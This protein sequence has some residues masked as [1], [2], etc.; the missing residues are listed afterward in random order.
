M[1]MKSGTS[2]SGAPA[3]VLAVITP[4]DGRQWKTALRP[5]LAPTLE[6]RHSPSLALLDAPGGPPADALLLDMPDYQGLLPELLAWQV[7]VPRLRWVLLL[8]P[9]E[10]AELPDA[11]LL[12]SQVQILPRGISPALV[13]TALRRAL[14]P[15]SA[16]Q[17]GATE[18][19]GGT[20]PQAVA[21]RL[22]YLEAEQAAQ[23]SFARQVQQSLLPRR[24]IIERRF[25]DSFV[26]YEAKAIVAGDLYWYYDYFDYFFVAV[27]D[28]TGYGVSGA[29]LSVLCSNLLNQLV[30]HQQIFA[31]DEVLNELHQR[32]LYSLRAS[33]PDTQPFDGIEISLCRIEKKERMIEFAGAGLPLW[34]RHAG[35]W[36]EIMGDRLPLAYNGPMVA[37]EEVFDRSFTAHSLDFAPGDQLYLLTDGV[38]DQFGGADNR[39]LGKRRLLDWLQQIQTLP[40][41]QQRDRLLEHLRT[42]TGPEDQ[43]DDWLMLGIRG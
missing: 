13:A 5:L 39:K 37:D 4:G 10:L 40:M 29:I 6:L 43:T 20:I 21:Q 24:N 35:D 32:V 30:V 27:A 3:G 31:T 22:Q 34:L 8:S 9:G 16:T 23:R 17:L 15:P 33:D 1:D 11:L 28:C 41:A 2:P 38:W 7:A 19:V 26:L 14:Q 18:S 36:Q 12:R 42:W 25:P